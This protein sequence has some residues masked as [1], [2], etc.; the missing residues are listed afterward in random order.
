MQNNVEKEFEYID[1]NCPVC[2][3]ENFFQLYKPTLK[4]NE[5]PV[6]GYD[7]ENEDQKKTFGYSKCN[8]CTH[9]FS[10]PVIKDLHK[11][12]VDKADESYIENSKFRILSYEHVVNTI[13]KF[14]PSGNLLDFGS[15]MGDFLV[16]AIKKGYKCVG[17]EL[18]NFS[19]KIS[20]SK[21]HYVIK[22]NLYEAE[23]DL[24]RATANENFDIIVMMGVI[25]HLERPDQ[26]LKKIS[27]YLNPGGLVVL[28]TGDSSSIFS[29]LLGKRWWYYIGQHIQ[30]FSRKSLT[31]LFKK[32]NF[33][34]IYNGNLPY[35]FDYNYLDTHLKRYWLYKNLF[36]F[37]IYPFLKLKK[38]ITLRLSSEI[39]MIFEK[40]S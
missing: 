8:N 1:I 9:I 12:Y 20:I 18:S 33:K 7:F 11:F 2:L 16:A 28:W 23:E 15:G 17:L 27:N 14:K 29:K 5:V 19:S 21:G 38:K 24:K 22:K 37:F 35:V 34:L 6:I 25:E 3:S 32:N 4:K 26:D 39:L 13:Y 31:Y 36:R 30:M 10:N 40:N